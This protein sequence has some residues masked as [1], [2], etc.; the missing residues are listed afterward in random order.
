MRAMLIQHAVPALGNMKL[1]D[2]RRRDLSELSVIA[3]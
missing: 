2:S 3:R 1:S